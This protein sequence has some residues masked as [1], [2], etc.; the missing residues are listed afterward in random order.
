MFRNE[1]VIS[2]LNHT[3]VL[4]ICSFILVSVYVVNFIILG[5]RIGPFD[6]DHLSGYYELAFRFWKTQGW[7]LPEFNPYLCGGRTL[8]GDPQI[9]LYHPFLLFLPLLGP[10]L[11]IKCEMLL[12]LGVG[13]WALWKLLGRFQVSE[14]G[15]IFGL[16]LFSA[17]GGVVS[18]FLVGHVT[19]GF[20]FLFP[21]LFYLSYR[22]SDS[23]HRSYFL[24]YLI[25][26]IYCG[27]YK[28]NFIVYAVPALGCEI[29][30]RSFLKRDY[31]IT[32]YFAIAVAICI[33]ANAANYLPSMKYF[34]DFPRTEGSEPRFIPPY[35]LAANLLLPLKMI[36]KILYGKA[37]FQR[38]EY[39]IFV[40]PVALWFSC[41]GYKKWT[42]YSAEK[43]SLLVFILIS[44]ILG[45]GTAHEHMSAFVPYTWL[46]EFWP[47]FSSIRVPTRFWFGCFFGIVILSSFGFAWPKSGSLIMTVIVL[48]LVPLLASATVNLFKTSVLA[49]TTQSE[50]AREYPEDIKAVM[51]DHDNS[52]RW[53]RRGIGVIDCVDNIQVYRSPLIQEGRA[54]EALSKPPEFT[55]RATWQN[56]SEFT[57]NADTKGVAPFELSLNLNH[58]D[59]WHFIEAQ[60]SSAKVVSR[61]GSPMILLSENNPLS[62]KMVY[63]QP[64][65]K[66]GL[67]L[68]ASTLFTL[69]A[70]SFFW[71]VWQ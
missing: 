34:A 61:P 5:Y 9:P 63:R 48:G 20:Y 66:E 14:Q 28:P 6:Y 15:K 22:L 7:Q 42:G 19:L 29:L 56:W 39:N 55:Y 43:T 31:K 68:S 4:S 49:K 32:L 64:Y 30:V 46:R 44:A 27:L 13:L 45:F 62:G 8:G 58:S 41:L 16:L 57:I 33:L 21:A 40:G 12:Q 17:G 53:I 52:Y 51:G 2:G 38:H 36:P 35:A 37:F 24:G 69:L 47:G 1:V 11:L 23:F 54:L 10:T 59:Y 26:F 71:R 50:F 60:G 67:W 3:R 18:K 65:L 70:L 25:L